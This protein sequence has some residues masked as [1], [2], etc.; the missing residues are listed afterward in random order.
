MKPRGRIARWFSSTSNRTFIVWPIV[1]AALEALRQGG[2]PY[3][4]P[5]AL[6]LLAWGYLQYRW[7]GGYRTRHGGGGPGTSVPPERIVTT[8]PYRLMRNPMYLGHII[9][10]VGLALVFRSWIAA[11]VLGF[12]LFWFNE[13]AKE[14]E[15]RLASLFGDAY[16]EYCRHVK[17]WIPGVY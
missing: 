12:H 16:R 8:G 14:D 9:F 13:R 7:V 3:I 11:A 2:I 17:R 5:L 1:I 6:P 15:A 4:D 10:F